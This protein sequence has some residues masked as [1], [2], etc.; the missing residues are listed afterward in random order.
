ML[1]NYYVSKIVKAVELSDKTEQKQSFLKV[2]GKNFIKIKIFLI[3]ALCGTQ[4]NEKINVII[5][6]LEKQVYIQT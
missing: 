2:K 6:L 1:R 4:S 5:A 3:F